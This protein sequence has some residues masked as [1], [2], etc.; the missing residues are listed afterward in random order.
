M[1]LSQLKVR[2]LLS[3]LSGCSIL[4]TEGNGKCLAVSGYSEFLLLAK[5]VTNCMLA[6][7]QMLQGKHDSALA[8]SAA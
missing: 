4:M 7:F 5:Q 2:H 1:R 3:K 8:Q 6:D